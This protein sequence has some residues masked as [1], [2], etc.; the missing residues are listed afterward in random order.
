MLNGRYQN[1][2]DSKLPERGETG[3]LIEG[4]NWLQEPKFLKAEKK[5]KYMVIAYPLCDN[6]LPYSIGI[7]T[8]YAR[9]L[10]DGSIRRVS[11]F[12]FVNEEDLYNPEI[13]Q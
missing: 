11:G 5:E 9:S 2:H 8:V 4:Y 6:G 1:F 13:I 3:Y 7:H 12:L 10:K